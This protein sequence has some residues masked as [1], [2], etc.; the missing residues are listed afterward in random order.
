[1]FWE[2]FRIAVTERIRYNTEETI[3]IGSGERIVNRQEAEQYLYY[4]MNIGELLLENGAE[5]GRVE[6]TV[7]R[8]CLAGG[9]ERADV[10]SITSNMSASIYG[11]EFG[12]CTQTRRVMNTVNDFHKLEELNCLS[13]KICEEGMTFGE[14]ER[15]IERI[16][17]EQGYSF[18]WLVLD[19]A[20]ISGS[21]CVFFGGNARDM[22]I[23]ALIGVLLK[24]LMTFMQKT[25]ANHLFNALIC[26]VAGGFLANL[27]VFVSVADHAD[28]ISIGNIMLLIPGIAFTNS[29]RDM[30]SGDTIT[31]L[32]RFMESILLAVIIAFGFNIAGVY[33]R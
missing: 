13:R 23:S 10:F 24:F 33:F 26:S 3:N 8:I 32:I 7:R 9:A 4:A 11:K 22:V 29:L 16:Q 2:N 25:A 15:E 1:M 28:R 18:W 20:L 5:V 21:F 31:G 14:I 27:A 19:Y 17:K 30:F 6:D 12:S